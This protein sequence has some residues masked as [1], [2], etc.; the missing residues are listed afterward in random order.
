[1]DTAV[2]TTMPVQ[3]AMHVRMPSVSIRKVVIEGGYRGCKRRAMYL[4]QLRCRPMKENL[5]STAADRIAR[6]RDEGKRKDG[7]EERT[8]LWLFGRSGSFLIY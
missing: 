3:L 4:C 8:G 6:I 7:G 5:A 2:T 1:M